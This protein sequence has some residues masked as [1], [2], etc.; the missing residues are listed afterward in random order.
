MLRSIQNLNKLTRCAFAV[1]P[2]KMPSFSPT[3]ETGKIQR[4]MVN[5]GDKVSMSDAIADIETDK[6]AVP[7]EAH[8]DYILA[9]IVKQAGPENIKVG[10]IIAYTVDD[11]AELENFSIE[12]SNTEQ[13][14]QPEPKT[15]AKK[16]HKD[17]TK[18]ASK[19]QNKSK[20]KSYPAHQALAMPALSPT[21]KA[22]KISQWQVKEGQHVM[23]GD[24]LAVIE[25][26][27]ASVDFEMQ[28][29]G[30]V[31]K[32]LVKD[33]EGM[34]D[35]GTDIIIIVDNEED[36][37]KFNDYEG[38]TGTQTEPEVEQDKP[39]KEQAMNEV[40]SSENQKDKQ[41]K[42]E[43]V[44]ISPKAK[45]LAKE[46]NI[47]YTKEGIKGSGPDGRI[48]AQDIENFKPSKKTEM[49]QKTEISKPQKKEQEVKK[50]PVPAELYEEI[51]L[52][53]M[54]RVIAERL[55]S[56]KQNIPHYYLT[57]KIEMGALLDFKKKLQNETGLKFS[58]SD[59]I[60]KAVSFA[61]QE[62]PEANSQWA[63]DRILRFQDVD[64]SFAVDTGDGLITPIIKKANLKTISAISKETKDL[65]GKSKDKKLKPEEYIGGTITISN[66]GMMG[67]DNFSAVINPPQSCILAIGKTTK[68]PVYDEKDPKG[69]RFAD[70][71]SVTLSCDHRVV[72]GAVG[73]KWLQSFKR[74]IENPLL[75]TL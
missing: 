62:V 55:T 18:V 5:E 27:K 6:A 16:E 52:S 39:Q 12:N 19:E 57:S 64:I 47:D 25:T 73:A 23:P 30:Y 8:D 21:M 69:F 14:S 68:E 11:E 32:I 13:Q 54:R 75:I 33:Q 2:I 72:D 31:A 44:F 53:N 1:N 42:G 29:E 37:D 71:M 56:S 59:F 17:E 38:N 74:Y 50:Q 4:W 40:K 51:P 70:I 49:A 48:I 41:T 7:L 34:V 28:E 36:I 67:I 9:K 65:I 61:C 22:G 45:M 26:D 43:K 35:V 46:K 58:V 24:I 15:E 66:L 63:G 60:V 20:A 3:M 10:E